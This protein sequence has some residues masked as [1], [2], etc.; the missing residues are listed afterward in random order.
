MDFYNLISYN[1]NILITEIFFITAIIGLIFFSGL[2]LSN[3]HILTYYT[4]KISFCLVIITFILILNTYWLNYNYIFFNYEFNTI[5]KSIIILSVIFCFILSENSILQTFEFS[6]LILLSLLGFILLTMSYDLIMLYIAIEIQSISFYILSCLKRNS[7]FSTEAGLKYFILGALASGLF[8]FG[9]S[10][11]YGLTGTTN[12]KEL[13]FLFIELKDEPLLIL[14]S[15]CILSA[16]LFKLSAA[17]FHI[18]SPDVYEGAPSVVT[19]FFSIT[20]KLGLFIVLSRFF[21]EIFY[22]LNCVSSWWIFFGIGCSLYSIWIG[23]ITAL[24]QTKLKRL[25]AYSAIGHVGYMLLGFFSGNSE[26]LQAVLFYLILYIITNICI[27]S[28]ILGINKLKFISQLK[29]V[30]HY[31]PFLCSALLVSFFSLAGVPPLAG[32]LAK[33]SVFIAAL[34]SNLYLVVIFSVFLSVISTF[35]YLRLIK[36]ATFEKLFFWDSYFFP[37]SI[38]KFISFSTSISFFSLFLFFIFPLPLSLLTYYLSLLCY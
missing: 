18:W 25:L 27:W 34:E 13:S 12:F 7:A 19:A 9:C 33:L 8:L 5:I 15:L 20:P 2:I 31:N 28:S 3:N 1:S 26:G 37:I 36:I 6:F 11:I 10:I 4:N 17:P 21:N 23:S 22:E 38:T 30:Y 35:Y 29:L 32:F 14:G 16:I 24:Q